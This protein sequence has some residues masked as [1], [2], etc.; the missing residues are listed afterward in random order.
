[1]K[2]KGFVIVPVIWWQALIRMQATGSTL[3]V[4]LLLLDKARRTPYPLVKLSNV[5]AKAVGVSRS[6]KARAISQLRKAGLIIVQDRPRRSPIVKVMFLKDWTTTRCSTSGYA[7]PFYL[8]LNY[9]SLLAPIRI[10]LCLINCTA[11][12]TVA[13]VARPCQKQPALSSPRTSRCYR[14]L[15]VLLLHLCSRNTTRIGPRT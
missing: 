9:R 7:G 2:Y 3:W 12:V 13:V 11:V 14:Q 10:S 6:S 8:I 1:M 5:A 4:A 15:A